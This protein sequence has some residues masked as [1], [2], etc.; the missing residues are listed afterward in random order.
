MES[1]RVRTD[2]EAT[3]KHTKNTKNY[4]FRGN[5]S[6]DYAL[7]SRGELNQKKEVFSMREMPTW[8]FVADFV[9][10]VCFVVA[11]S[12]VRT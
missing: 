6:R 10:F 2:R 5:S 4:G 1:R 12:S 8:R 3:T 7:V 11:S 9:S